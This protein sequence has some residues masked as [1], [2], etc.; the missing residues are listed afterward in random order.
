MTYVFVFSHVPL[1]LT[2]VSQVNSRPPCWAA[3]LRPLIYWAPHSTLL[4]ICLPLQ[5]N[6]APPPG[7]CIQIGPLKVHLYVLCFSLHDTLGW[8]LWHV[9]VNFY[10]LIL[11]TILVFLLSCMRLFLK[12]YNCLFFPTPPF[13]TPTPLI[14]TIVNKC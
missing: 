3:S 13:V 7:L 4:P 14:I 11:Y 5:Y 12:K 10:Y 8:F 9:Y 1:C 2:C 6:L